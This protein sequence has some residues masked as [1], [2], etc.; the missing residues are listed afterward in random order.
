MPLPDTITAANDPGRPLSRA[1]VAENA[2]RPLRKRA[3]QA[4]TDLD[5]AFEHVETCM[6]EALAQGDK[7]RC[8]ILLLRMQ[9]ATA[10]LNGR[11]Q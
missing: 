2:T 10:I 1:E 5:N 7:P 4:S 9:L 6:G 11:A 8:D 3:D